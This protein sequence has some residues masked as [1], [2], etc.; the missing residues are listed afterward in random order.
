VKRDSIRRLCQL[1]K[2][3]VSDL[4]EWG[5]NL[6]DIDRFQI[7]SHWQ[8]FTL[9]SSLQDGHRLGAALGWRGQLLPETMESIEDE[10][11]IYCTSLTHTETFH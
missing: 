6:L 8:A 9:S 4:P 10:M 11:F 7:A 1:Y 3:S 5:F 2:S